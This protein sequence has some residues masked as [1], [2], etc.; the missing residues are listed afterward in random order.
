VAELRPQA[1]TPLGPVLFAN[2]ELN[3]PQESEIIKALQKALD[4][5]RCVTTKYLLN[6]PWRPEPDSVK[7]CL[8]DKNRS[9]LRMEPLYG[10]RSL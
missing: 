9:R 6:S 4:A 3:W 1:L 5:R 2:V 7:D 8:G 10:K